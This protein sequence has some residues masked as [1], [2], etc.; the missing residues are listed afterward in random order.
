[1]LK[2]LLPEIVR[3]AFKDVPAAQ[4][5]QIRPG[6]KGLVVGTLAFL[7]IAGTLAAKPK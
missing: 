4:T 5:L 6:L 3:L 7:E 1:M 2:S